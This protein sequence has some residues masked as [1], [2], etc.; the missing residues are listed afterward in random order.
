MFNNF[1]GID[2]EGG[3]HDFS[4]IFSLNIEEV[5]SGTVLCFIKF[6]LSGQRGSIMIFV[7]NC[8]SHS[9]EKLCRGS[10]LSFRKFLRS[11]ERRE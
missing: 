3:H 9:L 1:S 11:N 10:V 4:L 5:C 7:E 6:L 8:L 2:T